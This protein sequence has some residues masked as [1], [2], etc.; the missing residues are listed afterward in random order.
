MRE[1]LTIMLHRE[2]YAVEA[3]FDGAQAVARLKEHHHDLVISDIK[4]PRLDGFGVLDHVVGFC[5]DTAIMITAFSTAQQA[6][7]AMKKGGLRLHHQALNNEEIRLIVKNALE[8]KELRGGRIRAQERV[9]AALLLSPTSSARAR[10]CSRSTT[11]SRR[12]PDSKANVLVAGESGTG[13]ELVAKAI[14]YNSHRKEQP[15]VPINCGAIPENLLESELFGHEKGAFT[16]A[17]QQKAGLFEVADGGTIFDE[18]PSWHGDDAG[19]AA[20]GVAG[21][22]R[23]WRQRGYQG[24]CPAGVAATNKDLEKWWPRKPSVRTYFIG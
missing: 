11:S 14:H 18:T 20:A 17:S 6:V 10:P 9:G 19:Q 12:W 4:M 3:A 24:R 21:E 1:F 16:G 7:D 5:P 13:K 23:Y 8:R 2:G 22:F 15:F